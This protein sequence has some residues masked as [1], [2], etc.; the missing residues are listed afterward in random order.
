MISALMVKEAHD[1][2]KPFITKTPLLRCYELDSVLGC[3]VYLKLE[4]L[5]RTGSFKIRGATNRLAI[6]SDSERNKGVVCAS[7]G[8]H[9]IAVSAAAERMNIEALVV[10][11]VNCNPTKLHRVKEYSSLIIH[12]GTLSSERNLKA[13]QFEKDGK[14]L[15]HSHADPY[16]LAGQ[17]TIAL[18]ILEDCPD[19]DAIV[20][21][22]GGGGLISG[23]STAIKGINS[24][25]KIIGSEPAS[26][27]RYGLSRRSGQP[28]R[29]K[30]VNT[31]ADGTRC[32]RA[33][34]D[35]FTT[36]EKNVDFLVTAS[37]ES[38]RD[39]MRL[40]S[41]KTKTI[42]EPSSS[43]G[44]GS[45]LSGSVSFSSFEQVCFVISGGNVDI[46]LFIST[47]SN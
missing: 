18:E 30:T 3:K 28:E 33:N 27:A 34:P 38:I 14:I 29:L 26:A 31:I 44:I 41:S 4:N 45:I 25:I 13:K 35:N 15:V 40:I 10:M 6:L 19:I 42:A 8:N 11:P 22:V 21:P 5:Q 7:S 24:S 23:I 2:I 46:D 12:E 43:L 37:E 17:G 39:A 16:V 1:R 20:V 36:I 9:A 47:F 32:D